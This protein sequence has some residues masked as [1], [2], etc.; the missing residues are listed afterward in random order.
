MTGRLAAGAGVSLSAAEGRPVDG[1]STCRVCG[2]PIES[3]LQLV[4]CPSCD[5]VAHRG[6]VTGE[7]CPE[8]LSPLDFGAA[9]PSDRQIRNASWGEIRGWLV[10]LIALT[11]AGAAMN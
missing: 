6:C 9:G 7:N 5:F 3:V 10:V 1:V 11:A 4:E 8:C 2:N